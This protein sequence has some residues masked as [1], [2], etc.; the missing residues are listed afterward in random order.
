MTTLRKGDFAKALKLSEQFN[1][2]AGARPNR[3][4]KA[5]LS[6]AVDFLSPLAR[7]IQA[8]GVINVGSAWHGPDVFLDEALAQKYA[9]D[10]DRT[11]YLTGHLEVNLSQRDAEKLAHIRKTF[12][13]SFDK[14]AAGLAIRVYRDVCDNLWRGNG[15]SIERKAAQGK[16]RE[17][18]LNTDKVKAVVGP[19]AIP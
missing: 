19:G 18:P 14:Q 10:K 6:K 4:V 3:R 5:V 15:F 2:K 1:I 13:L 11:D 8:G 12:N 16:G 7:E 17:R 9:R